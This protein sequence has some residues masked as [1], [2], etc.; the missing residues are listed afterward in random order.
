MAKLQNSRTL[1]ISLPKN[2]VNQLTAMATEEGR[3]P[4][5]LLVEG[6][7]RLLFDRIERNLETSR[8]EA[9]RRSLH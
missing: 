8:A 7:K 4:S 5:D 6:F 3:D 2:V 1:T 9:Q